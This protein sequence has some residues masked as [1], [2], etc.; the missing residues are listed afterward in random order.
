MWGDGMQRCGVESVW[1]C[2][3]MGWTWRMWGR[4]MKGGGFGGVGGGVGGRCGAGGG[5]MLCC[6]L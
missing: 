1:G 2:G 5:G 3:D 6:L 4:E